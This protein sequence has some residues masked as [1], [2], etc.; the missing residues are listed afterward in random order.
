M[1]L[2]N[3]AVYIF[4][5]LGFMFGA[6]LALAHPNLPLISKTSS[7]VASRDTVPPMPYP[8]RSGINS[9]L[10][11]SQIKGES[12]EYR[13]DV[14]HGG[15]QNDMPPERLNPSYLDAE[16]Y[17]EKAYRRDRQ[18]YFT[19]KTDAA[20]GTKRK[21]RGKG[22][23]DKIPNLLPI[24]R[25]GWEFQKTIFGSDEIELIPKGYF[26]LRVGGLY[27]YT[28][29]PMFPENTRG[30][31]A[32]DIDQR[33]QLNLDLRLGE[34]YTLKGI[35]DTKALFNFQN[36]FNTAY[37]GEEDDIIKKIELGNVSMTYKNSL[38]SSV[39]QLLGGKIRLQFGDTFVTTAIAKQNSK[40]KT[41]NTQGG[42]TVRPFSFRANDYDEDRHFF[43]GQYFYDH[44]DQA[45]ADLPLVNSQVNITRVEVWVTNFQ[46]ETQNIRNIIAF[47]DMASQKTHSNKV[48]PNAGATSL[49]QNKNN[50]LNPDVLPVE[51]PL[52]DLAKAAHEL[53][54][55]GYRE[56]VD[57]VRVESA[58]KLNPNE[59]TV[60]PRLGYVSMRQRLRPK[61]ILAVAFEYTYLGEVYK[62]GEFS[63]DGIEADQNILLKLIKSNAIDP[64][65][66]TW[67]W[68]MKNIY[69]LDG[70]DVKSENFRLDVLYAD[71]QTGVKINYLN[72][73]PL[74]DQ[75]LL[76]VFNLDRINKAGAPTPDG[77]FDFL[78]KKI[79]HAERGQVILPSVA[80]FG[81]FLEKKLEGNPTA[82]K[83]YVYKDLYTKNKIDAKQQSR[84]NKF[85]MEGRYSSSARSI[86][87]LG[88]IN[89]PRGSVK[90]TSGGRVLKEGQEYTVNYQSGEVRIIDQVLIDSRAPISVS[91]EKSGAFDPQN[92]IFFGLEVEH[93]LSDELSVNMGLAK[94]SESPFTPKINVG[95]ES[96]NNTM[97]SGGLTYNADALWLTRWVD[98]IPLIDTKEP[99]TI[100]VSGEVAYLFPS[101]P[102]ETEQGGLA[103][104]YLDDFEGSQAYISLSQPSRWVLSATPVGALFP[105]GD[106]NDSFTFGA[107]RAKL[108][109]YSIDP[110]FF[111]NS[112]DVPNHIAQDLKMLQNPSFRQFT[113]KE[114]FPNRDLSLGES[115]V[116]R[117]FDLA[118]FPSE[119][120]PYNFDTKGFPGIS[121]GVSATGE[122]K[123]PESR[124]GGVS[125]QIFNP[126][127]E[128]SN[129]EYI[130]FWMMD[131]F[132]ENPDHQGG[133]MYLHLGNISEDVI[134]D[135]AKGFEHG[136]PVNAEDDKFRYTNL[137]KV[138]T[139]QVSI[140]AFDNDYRLVQ[141]RGLDGMGNAEE[142]ER[143][144]DYL[145]EIRAVVRPGAAL[146]RITNDPSG[147]DY[148]YYRGT[149]LDGR[150]ASL[151]DRYKNFNNTE[152]NSKISAGESGESYATAS[153][154][155]P[156]VEDIDQDNTINRQE[157]Y[158]EYQIP[159]T[160]DLVDHR[161][162]KSMKTVEIKVRGVP[163]KVNWYQ[164]KIPVFTPDKSF[165]ISNF[166]N[167]R[168]MRMV[169]RG[170]EAPVLIR[171]VDLKLTRENW[172]RY[173]NSLI[174]G[175]GI[176]PLENKE[177]DFEISALNINENAT[178][179]PIP[180]V[181]PPG[182]T[183]EQ[184]FNTTNI[185]AQNEQAMVLRVKDLEGGD[186]RAVFK[187]FNTD[188]RNYKR[189]R[190]FV[191][192][193]KLDDAA[194]LADRELS[195]FLR[196]GNDFS[197]NY[198]QY[199]IPLQLTPWG[200]VAPSEIWKASNTLDVALQDFL[201]LKIER[202]RKFKGGV[203]TQKVY[204]KTQK[205]GHIIAVRGNPNM[206]SIQGIM[207]G[208]K[209]NN[210]I[211]QPDPRSVEIWVNELRLGGREESGGWA[212]NMRSQI[213]LA[214]FSTIS[215]NTQRK[216]IGFGAVSQTLQ[217]RS[218]TDDFDY[219]INGT[220]NLHKFFPSS[221][222]LNIPLTVAYS[223]KF[224]TPKYN[225]LI[226]DIT[227]QKSLESYET[228][229]QKDRVTR[230]AE[231]YT[232]RKS[233]NLDN[234]GKPPTGD[235]SFYSIENFNTSFG[236][237]RLY[238]RSVSTEFFN[239]ELMIGKLVYKYK[240]SDHG[241]KIFSLLEE[242]PILNA[243]SG[244][245]LSFL[246]HTYF[247]QA[248]FRRH[249]VSEKFRNIENPDFKIETFYNKKFTLGFQQ[250][251]QYSPLSSIKVS[252]KNTAQNIVDEPYGEINTPSKQG[253]LFKRI[254]ELGRP[255]EFHHDFKVSYKPL[256]G[257]LTFFKWLDARFSYGTV[258][259]W[260]SGPAA[261][262]TEKVNLGNQIQSKRTH[263]ESFTANMKTIY[264]EIPFIK[265]ARRRVRFGGKTDDEVSFTDYA[266]QFLTAIE[267][268]SFS[269]TNS[270]GHVFQGF[271]P[272]VNLYGFGNS[273]A[274]PNLIFMFGN[275]GALL[276]HYVLGQKIVPMRE[277]ITE[278]GWLTKSDR[279]NAPATYNDSYTATYQVTL[280]PIPYLNV[281]VRGKQQE[282]T[283]RSEIIKYNQEN[284]VYDYYR[285]TL[286]GSASF[287]FWT[288]PTSI[289]SGQGVFS[290]LGLYED[291]KDKSLQVAEGLAEDHYG[292]AIFPTAEGGYPEGF[293]RRH[294]RVLIGAFSS[295]YSGIDAAK[296]P[297]KK[298]FIPFP[299]WT[300][301][302]SGL[303]HLSIFKPYLSKFNLSHTYKSEYTLANYTSNLNY[304]EDKNK[305]N[306]RGDWIDQKSYN[307]VNISENFAPLIRIDFTTKNLLSANFGL[308]TTRSM[309]LNIPSEQLT[310]IYSQEYQVGLGYVIK[311]IGLTFNI[312]DGKRFV[313]KSDLDIKASMSYKKTR[314]YIRRLV[315]DDLQ[316][317]GG[318]RQFAFKANA[319][320]D[321]MPR[322]NFQLYFDMSYSDYATS[323]AYPLFLSRG[324]FSI[325]FIIGN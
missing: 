282:T 272:D 238:K 69:S 274:A 190:A 208:I 188:L 86:I 51:S 305:K 8:I 134:R 179:S 39:Q 140:R 245:K 67:K 111:G 289:F 176:T 101:S 175:D 258:Y 320:Y 204:T 68:M 64:E 209:S 325:K 103:T 129:V 182:I 279:F 95:K 211:T 293:S 163:K 287:S 193:E 90:V 98:Q 7:R 75:I 130:E 210:P 252:Y 240:R 91:L 317:I 63:T 242:V 192:A 290:T 85:I 165:R 302:Y 166:Q 23:T 29:N 102:S 60:H 48:T 18:R 310:E 299:N 207:L 52:R 82:I 34:K 59:Y 298:P 309:T 139:R 142:R 92:R 62:V 74:K 285:P 50:N 267:R 233:F 120:G 17:L 141:D 43:L 219:D 157:N 201:D 119:K 148:R 96:V 228:T 160:S 35:M 33:I 198:Y 3:V 244:L 214:D 231:D 100:S 104:S 150:E 127:F 80:P 180:Y 171:M 152:G 254:R 145:T 10:F 266:I 123:K 292:T 155:L 174:A 49:P 87:S 93:F 136:L 21:K 249:F 76:R 307:T 218:L 288:M 257:R 306:R 260:T 212:A 20:K 226:P 14:D 296:Y 4:A 199:E 265:D 135:G 105:E 221:W 133:Q 269:S 115:T 172:R 70:Y 323:N 167:I 278:K 99:S 250:S 124:W 81:S 13:Y 9:P 321:I 22:A 253:E 248:G 185:Q 225:P 200:T 38:M 11:L 270:F 194:P 215:F 5:F 263:I 46:E 113:Y 143:F 284:Q 94:L 181:L 88:A 261:L 106:D 137:A 107:N 300:V 229:A 15:F 78:D 241:F 158:H 246:P 125:T 73:G 44:F 169:L 283:F 216:S 41:I 131:P 187:N 164:I 223:E 170:F 268:I 146:D 256:L 230:I 314:S 271:T 276:D 178:R 25:T 126:N 273:G 122:L 177:T 132:F 191:H 24:F 19:L 294:Q 312:N 56:S 55:L 1:R 168:F 26:T 262:K 2:R 121:Q 72:D 162:V 205:N 77:Y 255:Q 232:E 36:F 303:R 239:D 57:Y 30:S 66:P 206:G 31:F 324:G 65:L 54:Q 313:M 304:E 27:Q 153:T 281:S 37:T 224:I 12:Q 186:A 202:N 58:R 151:L 147:D 128:V 97:W 197:E 316:V 28:D 116:I 264:K 308:N 71:D 6:S 217:E 236:V 227:F 156:D 213:T 40:S 222:H 89:V 144:K 118:F 47:T 189:I 237:S 108:A 112:S 53:D 251:F 203:S 286:G 311:N 275:F 220:F 114:L 159:L 42:G 195:F 84:Y 149:A 301:R 173:R 45:L 280:A 61:Q 291:M 277:L 235:E 79:I 184:T 319:S 110:L 322:L 138:P 32:L 243:F 315:D 247:I 196:M 259:D 161:Y 16:T 117:T 318:Q 109:W 183:R 295:A 297:T 154:T 83:K 234:V